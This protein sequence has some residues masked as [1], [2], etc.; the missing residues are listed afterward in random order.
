[1]KNQELRLTP[2]QSLSKR[3]LDLALSLIC[4]VLIAPLMLMISLLVKLDGPG[5]ILYKY[6]RLGT[7]GTELNIYRFRTMRI[8]LEN[9]PILSKSTNDDPRITPFGL[10]LRRTALDDLPLF[11]NVF[12]GDMSIV[13][14]RPKHVGEYE[15]Y[16][17]IADITIHAKSGITSLSRVAECKL[18]SSDEETMK[19]LY[20]F[21]KSYIQNWSIWLDLKIIVQTII[22]SFISSN[23]Y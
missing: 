12:M 9:S 19:L 3:L 10:F 2:T 7:N 21:E 4:L 5:P 16:K 13:G 23:A 1:M 15:Y 14:P 8:D 17:S 6:R 11:L 20:E 22:R 18:Y